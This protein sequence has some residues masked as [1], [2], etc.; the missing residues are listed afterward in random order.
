MLE[1]DTDV[2]VMIKKRA[3][4]LLAQQ[5]EHLYIQTDHLFCALLL[6]EW[7]AGMIT[8]IVIS[9]LTWA[10]RYSD[11]HMHVWTAM[12]LGALIVLPPIMLAKSHPGVS[13]TRYI[14][15][16]GQMLYSALLIHLTGGR[17]ETHF[18]VFGSLAFLSFY[19]DWRVF[20]P[21]TIIVVLDHALRGLYFPQSVY[22]VSA[23]QPMRW[24]EHAGW[25]VFENA[26]LINM[27]L[28]SDKE[29]KI[30]SEHQAEVEVSNSNIEN[31]VKSR[32]E[33]LNYARTWSTIQYHVVRN[34]AES[35]SWAESV[36]SI[37][38]SMVTDISV[39]GG[40]SH[41][42][43]WNN[44]IEDQTLNCIECS[45][46]PQGAFSAF[47][48]SSR[49]YS[50]AFGT[51]LPGLCWSR[52]MILEP[53]FADDSARLKAASAAGIHCGIAFP[54]Y[55]NERF[56]GVF[57]FYCEHK[58]EWNIQALESMARQ[59]GQ[60]AG[61]LEAERERE[62]LIRVVQQSSD[63]I[64]T[65]TE[66]GS[67]KSWNKGAENLL[68]IEES[69][70]I[71]I[72]LSSLFEGSVREQ[73]EC[74]LS[75]SLPNGA[76]LEGVETSLVAADGNTAEVILFAIPWFNEST[77]E[78]K[79]ASI[80]LHNATERK[81]AERRVSEFYSTVSHELRTP[82][83][84]IKGALGLIESNT[85]EPG[86]EEALELIQ[87]ASSSSERLIRLIND[88]LDLEK[89]KAGKLDL[90]KTIIDVE[91]L[92]SETICALAGMSEIFKVKLLLEPNCHCLISADWDKITQVVTNLVSNA[93]KFSAEGGFVRVVTEPSNY[94]NSI[95]FRIIDNGPGISQSDMKRLF[96]KFQQLDASD[97]RK[98][99]GTGLGL[100]IAKA[101]V[102]QHGGK[103]GVFS[104]LGSGSEFWFDLPTLSENLSQINS[105]TSQSEICELA[106]GETKGFS[107]KEHACGT[108]L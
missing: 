106:P 36:K 71:G 107:S 45:G 89:I 9:P 57:E 93:I 97:T 68:A 76:R 48:T 42:A 40:R 65:I 75:S 10:G 7:I 8:A 13:K 102:E 20:V 83:T 53:D 3:R 105:E 16:T 59:I 56:F 31:I 98:F 39:Q 91:K 43:F 51:G 63:A 74:L 35:R 79:G 61:R 27:C 96:D 19:R 46:F 82:L 99:A 90:H 38:N 41:G 81:R 23:V 64:I 5:K 4:E 54:V 85:I 2:A 17:I 100:A 55:Y 84:S 104:Q 73:I 28:R 21:A 66:N 77:N 32:T 29:M 49:S 94:S 47:S 67:I 62:H 11:I 86:S 1:I 92:A 25:V 15:A 18:H 58:V 6:A 103:I 44:K 50:F 60:Y 24:L 80:T 72:N 22:G 14:I 87:V 33:Q 70:A 52:G 78:Y 34:L 69:Q 37:L 88:I 26:F 95:R 12:I 101:I 108:K 30:N